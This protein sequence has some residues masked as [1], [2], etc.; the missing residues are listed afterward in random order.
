MMPNSLLYKNRAAHLANSPGKSLFFERFASA[1]STCKQSEVNIFVQFTTNL[2]SLHHLTYTLLSS[3][4]LIP[5]TDGRTNIPLLNL[6]GG[7]KSYIA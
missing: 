3:P 6:Q 1:C 5:L 4:S 7:L 2:A